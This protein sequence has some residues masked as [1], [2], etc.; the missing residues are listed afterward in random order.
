MEKCGRKLD[1]DSIKILT[2][3]SIERGNINTLSGRIDDPQGLIIMVNL[4]PTLKDK[5]LNQSLVITIGGNLYMIG[6]NCWNM[7]SVFFI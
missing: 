2:Q 5:G 7:T 4:K 1:M 3:E 6:Y